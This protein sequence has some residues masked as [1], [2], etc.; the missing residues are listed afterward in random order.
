MYQ[1]LKATAYLHSGEVIHRDQKV[2][3]FCLIS[4]TT[5]K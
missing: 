3:I 1:L 4:L 5:H 2:S